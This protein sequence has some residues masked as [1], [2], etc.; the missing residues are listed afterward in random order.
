VRE[1]EWS[2]QQD[3]GWCINL[4]R[5]LYLVLLASS[6]GF[7]KSGRRE[8]GI[9]ERPQGAQGRSTGKEPLFRAIKKVDSDSVGWCL[10]LVHTLYQVLLASKLEYGQSGRGNVATRRGL[11]VMGEIHRGE[12][13]LC[14]ATQKL[15]SDSVGWYL[16]LVHTLYQVLL[17]SYM[18]F[19]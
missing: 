1:R 18:G 5:T 7:G 12:E 6:M 14:R 4:V 10:N 15:D 11:E 17:A 2:T 9:L 3:G 13:P 19:G 8:W 16:S